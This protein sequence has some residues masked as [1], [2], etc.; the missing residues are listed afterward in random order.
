MLN[1][2]P[3]ATTYSKI[4][5]ITAVSNTTM[6][7]GLGNFSYN[8]T[9]ITPTFTAGIANGTYNVSYTWTAAYSAANCANITWVS[10]WNPAENKY[11]SF[12]RNRLSTGCLYTSAQYNLTRGDALWIAVQNGIN[13]TLARG[14]W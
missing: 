10:F 11:C 14:S 4:I 12:Y 7:I 13:I 2:T 3:A 8:A 6:S 9:H 5:S 1:T